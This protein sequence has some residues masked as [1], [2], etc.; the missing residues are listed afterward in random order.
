MMSESEASGWT[1]TQVAAHFRVKPGTV[2]R[3]INE[4]FIEPPPQTM[5]GQKS[6]YVFTSEWVNKLDQRLR[7]RAMKK[8][9]SRNAAKSPDETRSSE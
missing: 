4:G 7:D 2:Y 8:A 5:H 3:W 9:N 6:V 1:A